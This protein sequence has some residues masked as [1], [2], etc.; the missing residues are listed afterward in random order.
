MEKKENLINT[1]TTVRGMVERITFHNPDNGFSVLK[2][3]PGGRRQEITVVGCVPGIAVGE[4]LEAVGEWFRDPR[5][6]LQLKADT[7]VSFPPVSEEGMARYLGSGMIRGIGPEMADRLVKAFGKDVF[8]VIEDD[9]ERLVKVQGIGKK[10]KDMISGAWEEQKKIR[11]IMLFLHSHGVGSSRAQRIYKFYGDQAVGLIKEDPYRLSR[12]IWGIGFKTADS[13][14][15]SLGVPRHSLSRACAGIEYTL[16]RKTEEGHCAVFREK[17]ELE[18]CELLEIPPEIIKEALGRILEE[19][20]LVSQKHGA[21]DLIYP[22]RLYRAEQQLAMDLCN[23]SAG[24]HPCSISDQAAVLEWVQEQVSMELAE[25]QKQALLKALEKKVLVITGGPGVGK[26]T[27]VNSIV[28][29]FSSKRMGIRLC[30]PTGRAAKRL[31]ETTGMEAR[32]IH[33]LLEFDPAGFCFTRNRNNPLDGDVIICDE[34][35][36]VDLPLA[37]QLIQAVPPHAALLIVGDV[38]QLPSVGPGKILRDIIDSS[39]IPVARLDEV[40]RQASQSSIITNAHLVNSGKMPRLINETSDGSTRLDD[41]YHIECDDPEKGVAL[42]KKL[43]K[44]RAPMR[45]GFNPIRDIQVL[46]PMI[47]GLLG[48]SNLNLELQNL[49]N[50]SG[51]SFTLLGT[52]FRLGDK[53]MQVVNNYDKNVFNGDMGIISAIDEIE[54]G[55][56]VQIDDRQ[57]FYQGAELDEL[58]L[59]YAVTIH[60]SQGSEY[61]C[62]VIPF[63]T[64]HYPMM[65]RNLL[66]TGIT[67]GKRLVVLVGNRKALAIAVKRIGADERLTSLDQRLLEGWN[68]IGSES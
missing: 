17:L 2:V 58:V 50:P 28:R 3:K 51:P 34:F 59:S 23:L 1:E 16:D 44:E 49:L 4:V 68:R 37:F 26:T 56:A 62:V 30:A 31:S 19:G 52:T 6:G 22:S 25:S 42:I 46:C 57:V 63:H 66:Y 53:V 9:P 45:W 5:H 8:N 11:S 13:I 15:E 67:R 20:R 18:S 21:S 40:F 32:T 61:P 36:M 64:Q 29:I 60:K 54:K 33:R 10:R 65:Q 27:L 48:A 39:V 41:F 24:R 47:R 43:V 38:D 7:I 55:L 14:A 35:S 12:D